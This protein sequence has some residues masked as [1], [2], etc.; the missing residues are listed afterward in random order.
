MSNIK[1]LILSGLLSS[2]AISPIMSLI[3]LSII[4]SNITKKNIKNSYFEIIS[5]IYKNKIKIVRPLLI[6][7]SV[8]TSTFCS[9]NL[10]KY[11][12]TKYNI[13]TKI[14]LIVGTAGI[15]IYMMAYKDKEYS[16]IFGIKS[17]KYSFKSYSLFTIGAMFTVYGNFILK[18]DVK[19]KLDSHLSNHLSNL[20]SSILVTTSAQFF[21][22]PFHILG[23]NYY[24]KVDDGL[25]SRIKNI[26][27]LYWTVCLARMFRILP[28]FGIGS[29]LN[30]Y[31]LNNIIF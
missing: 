28:S 26:K 20:L 9:A 22:T 13:N 1:E 12:S 24:Q 15:N 6:I 18:N 29:T 3:D 27:K 25:I 5:D 8:Y 19:N 17:H 4:K 14:P 23:L 11:Y 31:L 21:S 16:K 30:D 7:N 2:T 10:I